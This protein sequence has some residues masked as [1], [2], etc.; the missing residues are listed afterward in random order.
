MEPYKEFELIMAEGGPDRDF[1]LLSLRERSHFPA[2]AYID[3]KVWEICSLESIRAWEAKKL[4]FLNEKIKSGF[5]YPPG[6]IGP[7]NFSEQV[8]V[9]RK[10]FPGIGLANEEMIRRPL[11]LGAEGWFAIPR[12]ESI[13]KDYNQAVKKVAGLIQESRKGGFYISFFPFH[14]GR[15][16][17]RQ[18]KE[19]VE[20][21]A[22]LGEDQQGY[23]ILAAPAQFGFRYR[24]RSIRGARSDMK[25]PAR[26]AEF[27]LGLFAVGCMLLTHP[28]RLANYND[29]WIDCAGDDL[30]TEAVDFFNGS[31][32][33]SFSGSKEGS[34]VLGQSYV[35]AEKAN[36]GSAS[37]FLA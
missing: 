24:G 31:P 3:D 26:K 28:E 15:G 33:F 7:K 8:N 14:L 29:L 22:A 32:C 1:R 6:Y 21:F 11:P 5:K 27:G 30:A 2:Y 20:G 4:R 17:L 34:M 36:C 10:I 25:Q 9:L 12:W 16:F 23:D 18:S 19:L 13:A 35:M 37:A